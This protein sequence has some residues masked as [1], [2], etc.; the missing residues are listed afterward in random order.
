MTFDYS[1]F[2]G[3][4][5]SEIE[6]PELLPSTHLRA[7]WTLRVAEG[8]PPPLDMLSMGER[9]VHGERYRL[10]RTLGGLRLEYAHS[11][12]YDISRD[13]STIVWYPC[14]SPVPELVRANVLGPILALALESAG[15]FCLHGSAV[16][17]RGRAVA[18]L[19]PKHHGKSTLAA[20]LTVAGARLASDDLVAIDPGPPAML[21]PGVPSVRLLEDAARVTNVAAACDTAIAGIKT[22]ATGFRR[23]SLVEGAIPL[24]AIYVLSPT[25]AADD[26][27][28]AT[29][30]RLTGAGAIV[31]LAQQTKLPDSLIGL[32]AAAAQLAAAKTIAG[33]VPIWTLNAAR[34]LSRL[35]RVIDQI[36]TWHQGEST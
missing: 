2:G 23:Q 34:D 33:S 13:G 10:W 16:G 1:V 6:F 31:A 14:A 36:L 3:M 19:G 4:L 7:T 22:T 25:R 12:C 20:A 32:S 28:V 24:D 9:E 8:G 29:R 17:I 30:T 18:F 11:G 5:R 21:L 15:F 35:G 26:A 27:P